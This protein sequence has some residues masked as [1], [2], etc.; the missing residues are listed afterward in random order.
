[1]N[2]VWP[3]LILVIA[4]SGCGRK[5]PLIPPEALVPATVNNLAVLQ[6]GADLRLDWT[7]PSREKGGRALRDLTGFRL[8]RRDL[9]GDGSD[10]ALCEET[11]KLLTNID[12]ELP[13]ATRRQ[14]SDFTYFDRGLPVGSTVQYRLTALSRSGG[15][16]DPATSKQLKVLPPVAA[17]AITATATA[18][19]VGIAFT[20]AVPPGAKLRGYHVYRRQDPDEEPS[21][22][23][24]GQPVAGPLW[25]DRQVQPGQSYRYRATALVE[26]GGETVE[27]L[28]SAEAGIAF[29]LPELH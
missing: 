22:P 8:Q 9:A 10:C 11:W 21:R 29:A 5:G 7:A 13:G 28:P 20:F 12:V 19:G 16:S 4:L 23:F 2:R 15:K 18:E 17:P 14:G 24:T 25:L 1:M 27:S 6:Q 3:L 26:S